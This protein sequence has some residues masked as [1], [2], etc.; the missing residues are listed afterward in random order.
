MRFGFCGRPICAGRVVRGGAQILQLQAACG[1]R[2]FAERR[3]WATEIEDAELGMDSRESG[4]VVH[5]AL[6]LFWNEVETQ[7]ALKAMTRGEQEARLRACI[8]A[9][10]TKTAEL[11]ATA[12]GEAYLDMQPEG[13][14]RL[15]GQWLELERERPEVEVKLSGENL[16]DVGVGPLLL[17]GRG[18]RVAGAAVGGRRIYYQ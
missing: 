7:S 17:S 9:A 11:S 13:L 18:D 5:K 1:F 15:L 12:W 6:E 2:A 4:T 16:D 10:L 3:L 8:D 14:R